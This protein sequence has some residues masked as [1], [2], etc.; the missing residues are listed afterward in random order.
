[1]DF[2]GDIGLYQRRVAECPGGIAQRLAVLQ[3][4]T[5]EIGHAAVDVGCGGGHL[6]REMANSVGDGGRAVG[7]DISD[8]QVKSANEYC[9]GLEAAQCLVGDAK[10]M[11]FEDASF[12]RLAS[13]R[14]LE[15]IDDVPAALAEIRRVLRP[16]GVAA[17]VSVLWDQFRFHGPE[18]DLNEKILEAFRGHCPH[19]AL[20][21]QLPK[22]L[23]SSGF[24]GAVQKP[25]A[26]FE[27]SLNEN[28]YGFWVSKLVAG[29]AM[30]AGVLKED[31]ELWLEQLQ[32]AGHDRRFGF[33]SMPVLTVTNVP[34]NR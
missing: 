20:P 18:P 19:Q 21:M 29:F 8:E 6:V 12:D 23:V 5:L 27:R 14:T 34:A 25:V 10:D 31:A 16:G 30:N 15:Y 28:C 7:L 22:M 11:N 13:I 32:Q 33:V 1:M 9:S 2:A 3:S 26:L 24:V 17:L 4:L